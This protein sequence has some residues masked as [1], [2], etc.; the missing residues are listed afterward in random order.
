M[1]TGKMLNM[2]FY[3]C[4]KHNL[5]II[6]FEIRLKPIKILDLFFLLCAYFSIVSF[7]MHIWNVAA[8]SGYCRNNDFIISFRSSSSFQVCFP[9]FTITN[10]PISYSCV[11]YGLWIFFFSFSFPAFYCCNFLRWFISIHIY[12]FISRQ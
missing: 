6:K 3:S 11:F 2:T 1:E 12:T 10:L 5:M 9:F 7:Y 8:V 4:L